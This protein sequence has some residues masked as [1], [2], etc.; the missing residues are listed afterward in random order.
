MAKSFDLETSPSHL[1]RRANQYANDLYTN[2]Q[3]SKILTQRQFAVL[4]AIDQREGMSQTELVAA[5]GIDRS[6]LA[7]MIVRMQ[8]KDYL[9]RK[10]T[11]EDQRANSVRITAAGRR[12]LKTA[13]PAVV[14]SEARLLDALPARSRSEFIKCLILLAKADAAAL[15]AQEASGKSKGR[16]RR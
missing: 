1:L 14:K 3:D 11:E 4:F 12:A 16:R 6:T 2:E 13:L 5:T 9:A 15:A 7:D 10:R 8:K